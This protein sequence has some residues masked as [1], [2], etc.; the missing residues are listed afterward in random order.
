LLT[1]EGLEALLAYLDTDRDRAGEKYE[2]IR[3]RLM[4]LFECRG[5]VP[6]EEPADETI[7]RVARRLAEG[8]QIRAAS[9]AAYFY[10]VARNVLR[11]RWALQRERREGPT[12][13]QLPAGPG[14]EVAAE[15]DDAEHRSACLE[16]CLDT[17][18]AETQRLVVEYYRQGG[19]ASKI[20][21]RKALAATLGISTNAL[22]V[23]AH[24][25]R[26][27]LERCVRECLDH[28]VAS[29]RPP[30][31]LEDEGEPRP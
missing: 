29:K 26:S 30:A 20:V 19:G 27:R 25:A 7:D 12:P 3:H 1:R 28:R 16:K 23:R 4:K 17:L 18:P 31:P 22:W 14:P 9:P 13:G 21:G 8:E 5:I 2:E 15:I 10:G 6:S 24:R 11:E